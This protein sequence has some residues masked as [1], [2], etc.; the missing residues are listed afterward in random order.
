MNRDRVIQL[1]CIALV[2]AGLLGCAMMSTVIDGQRRELNIAGT[3]N[4]RQLPPQEALATAAL[5]S[6]RGIAIDALWYRTRHLQSAGKFYEANTLAGWITTLQPRFPQVWLFQ[7]W[8]MA[9]NISVDTHTPQE[10]WDWVQKGIHLLRDKGIPNNPQAVALYR[11][12][13]WFFEH[14]IGMSSDDMHWYY[15][16]EL[17]LRWQHLLGAPTEGA[18]TAQVLAR[19]APIATMADKYVRFNEPTREIEAS[20]KRLKKLYP[21]EKATFEQ[22]EV[23]VPSDLVS[24]LKDRVDAW[25]STKPNLASQ[26][27]KILVEARA[28]VARANADKLSLFLNDYPQAEP[29]VDQLRAAGLKLDKQTLMQLGEARM[30]L[31]YYDRK[32]VEQHLDR[33]RSKVLRELI[34]LNLKPENHEGLIETLNY[35]RANVLYHDY[36]MDPVFM[37]QL[38]QKY[39]PIDWRHP[40][41]QGLYWYAMGVKRGRQVGADPS[42]DMLNTSRG[43]IQCVQGLMH[44]GTIIFDPLAGGPQSYDLMPDTRFIPAYEKA[45][46]GAK[47]QAKAQG[48]DAKSID[49]FKTGFRNFLEYAVRTCYLYGSDAEAQKYF[50]QLREKFGDSAYNKQTGNYNLPLADFVLKL[51]RRDFGDRDVS[52]AF[53]GGMLEH[54]FVE[55]LGSGKIGVYD[56]FQHVAKLA[57]DQYQK[58]H[59]TV[60]PGAPQNRESLPPFADVVVNSYVYLMRQ[61]QFSLL[62]RAKLYHNTPQVLQKRA[63]PQFINDIRRQVASVPNGNQLD[64]SRAFPPPPGVSKEKINPKASPDVGKGTDTIKRH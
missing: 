6:F 47:Q 56:H 9:Y 18:D 15:K 41:A 52:R 4:D 10:R 59:H 55:G 43:V 53:I 5:G 11:E 3:V 26:L 40:D 27:K 29:I 48:L 49:T 7:A 35:L 36:H 14:K 20:L 60:T 24:L 62:F 19:F 38:M 33:I 21:D 31:R 44:Q 45:L 39:G 13:G 25:S 1:A 37:Y 32:A 63:Y 12:L 23:A 8:N 64:L 51:V 54:G 57:Y 2:I 50:K 30:V 22:M 17:A 16:R 28:Q 34:Q 42:F 46:Y 58:K 61:P